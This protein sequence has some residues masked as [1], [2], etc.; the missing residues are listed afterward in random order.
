M[1][2]TFIGLV[3][4]VAAASIYTEYIKKKSKEKKRTIQVPKDV[5]KLKEDIDIKEINDN[6][7]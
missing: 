4:G 1:N 2:Y 7:K 3:I 5:I 6:N